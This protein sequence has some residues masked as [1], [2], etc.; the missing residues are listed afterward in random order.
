MSALFEQGRRAWRSLAAATARFRKRLDVIL[1]PMRSA[2]RLRMNDIRVEG[3]RLRSRPA[4]TTPP[5]GATTRPV[6]LARAALER[7]RAGLDITPHRRGKK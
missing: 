7:L 6:T 5:P 3:A 2:E 4:Q 1:G